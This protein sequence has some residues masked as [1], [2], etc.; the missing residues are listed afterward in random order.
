LNHPKLEGQRGL[1]K[2]HVIVDRDDWE[3]VKKFF[4]DNPE[5]FKAFKEQVKRFENNSLKSKLQYTLA[6]KPSSPDWE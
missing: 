3:A 4:D 1:D 5:T 6:N 2:D